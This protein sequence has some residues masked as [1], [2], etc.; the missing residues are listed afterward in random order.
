MIQHAK[1]ALQQNKRVEPTNNGPKECE[2]YQDAALPL[3]LLM[4][5]KRSTSDN[6]KNYA[7][8]LINFYTTCNVKMQTKTII[9]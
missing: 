3:S 6:L 5:L 8:F 4:K 7:D 1:L 9:T 2:I